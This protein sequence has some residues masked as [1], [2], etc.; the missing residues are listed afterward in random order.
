MTWWW[1]RCGKLGRSYRRYTW[2]PGSLRRGGGAKNKMKSNVAMLM[3]MMVT[4]AAVVVSH[5]RDIFSG[6]VAGYSLCVSCGETWWW[7]YAVVN[8]SSW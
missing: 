5:E 8:C 1:V 6:S 4:T 7:Q 3:V 2:G